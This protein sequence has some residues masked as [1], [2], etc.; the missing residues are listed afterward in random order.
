MQHAE[1][2]EGFGGGF[3]PAGRRRQQGAAGLEFGQEPRDSLLLIHRAVG[4]RQ[5]QVAA[6]F[7]DGVAVAGALLADIEAGQAEG[8]DM[9]LAEQFAQGFAAQAGGH[10]AV[11]H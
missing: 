7:V 8:E 3:T 10:Q 6:E 11:A 1:H 4:H 5:L 9:H 2:G